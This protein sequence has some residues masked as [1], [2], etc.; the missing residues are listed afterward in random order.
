MSISSSIGLVSGI[1]S[2][3]IIQQLLALDAQA[4]TPIFQ[5]IG[6]LNA[7]N[8]ALLDVNA[9]LLAFKSASST[10]RA[11]DIFRS[12]NAMSSDE[13]VLLANARSS[14][15]PGQYAFRVKQLVSTSQVMSGGFTSSTLEPLGLDS[16][17]FEWGN[18]RLGREVL[19]ED[20]NGGAG[21]ERGSIRI[22]DRS[23]N[24][25]IVDLSLAS[26]ITEVIDAINDETGI[27]VTASLS[28][29]RIVIEDGS[30]GTG[31]LSIQNAGGTTTA[32]DLGIVANVASDV[33]A[34]NVVNRLDE[35]TLLSTLN[36][37]N[38]VLIRDN[39]VDFRIRV[40]GEGGTIHSIDLGRQD[41]RIDGETL[42][43]DL[44]DGEGI[45][46]NETTGQPD[47]SIVTTDGTQVDI[48]LGQ[49][50]DDDGEVESEAVTNVQEL[51]SRVNATL[52]EELGAGQVVM[53]IDADGE[54]FSLVDAMGG[55]G[56]LEV[57]GA[58]PFDAETA[59]DLGIFT[60]SGGG[61]G[62]S[63]EGD[64]LPNTVEIASASTIQDVIDRINEQTDGAVSA[65]VGP[66]G[67][68]IRLV[69]AGELVT[70][71]D[72]GVGGDYGATTLEDLGFE[73][74]VESTSLVGSRVLGGMGTVLVDTING[75][76]GLGGASS[77][78]ITD[79]NG[80]SVTVDNLGVHSTMEELVTFIN[81]A[82]ELSGVAVNVGANAEG[83]GLAVFDS[84]GGN[85]NLVVTGDAATALGIEIDVAADT[86]RGLN[87]QRQYVSAASD[88]A[89]LN[90][91]R[92]VGLGKFR[93]TDGNGISAVVDIGNDSK[94]L[95]DVMNEINSRG[96]DVEARLNENG[97]GMIL[98]DTS[99]GG[100]AKI[101]V[102][103]I[104]GSTARDL[105]ILGEATAIGASID[106]SYER[107]VDLDVTDTLD[108]V[109]GKINDAGL[110][111]AA[112]LLDTNTG[113]SPLRLVLSSDISGLA[114]DL[115]VDTGGIDLGFNEL[116]AA[117]N[118][119]V[120]IGEG[121][122]G[123]LVEST[124]NVIDNIVAGVEIELQSASDS[125]VTVNVTRDE[126]GIVDSVQAFVDGFNGVIEVINQYDSYDS[127]SEIRGPLLGDPTVAKIKQDLY[128]ILQQR[129]VGVDTQFNFL[130]EVGIR[131]AGEGQIEFDK[132]RFE[133]A[134]ADDPE[135]VENLF[136]AYESTGTSTETIAPGVT[137]DNI[138]TTYDELGFGDLF[139]QA[140]EKLT[141]SIDG[142]VTLASR[143]FD[144]L[145]DAQKDRIE[146]IDQRLAAKELRLFR[147]FT[148]ME[149]TLA[150][151]QSQQSS[152]G[153]IS[154][155][156]ANAGALIG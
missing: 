142:T 123:V 78:T 99:V 103:S 129:A 131:I 81:D 62:N 115:I 7:S 32:T 14:A 46:I 2:G 146:E 143:N 34:G 125:P 30:G 40:G 118:A 35:L 60:G 144:A 37:D 128:R 19:L 63:I 102:E 79:R 22:Q 68:G 74:G 83:N 12:T 117:R 9:R 73:I 133:E 24:A 69:A 76:S 101:K 85:Q 64:R 93:I 16:M 147:E 8:A 119:K 156:L 145:I 134:Y 13:G 27:G 53:S 61:S 48:T 122:G 72:D 132:G 58:G 49:I 44:N 94:K 42:L 105:G 130:A 110:A 43:A 121:A 89:T 113:G 127:E 84:T 139:K 116:T 87:I 17:S 153:M 5:R 54:G 90:Y 66:D 41:A 148:A 154:Q 151:L 112:S 77:I 98:V 36:D 47:F 95:F 86:A 100:S 67:V 152:L 111:V 140:I 3:A 45:R 138:T 96:L 33:V 155:N 29:D 52:E 18:G 136:A 1:D 120:F 80:E 91:G 141:N 31:N 108:E 26:S 25:A 106:G 4:K 10:F 124:S 107:S 104:S 75:G 97:D 15:I 114:G 92:G 57:I 82:A 135:A 109:I 88:L 55:G 6:G 50:L 65:S 56:D 59:E 28:G 70:V 51:L 150:R 149:T 11:D 137:V 39:V 71:L 23:G 21:V 126:T 38:G 20:L